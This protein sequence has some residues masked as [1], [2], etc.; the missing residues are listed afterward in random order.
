[1]NQLEFDVK[2]TSGDLY[3]YM[4]RHTYHS[5]QGLLGTCVGALAIFIFFNSFL[6]ENG[7]FTF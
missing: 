4:L 2:I 1:M 6:H 5:A 3:D 7:Y